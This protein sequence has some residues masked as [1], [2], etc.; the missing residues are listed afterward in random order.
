MNRNLAR[1]RVEPGVLRQVG[2]AFPTV[3]TNNDAHLV[4]RLRR[5]MVVEQWR[6]NFGL[7]LLGRLIEQRDRHRIREVI[8]DVA[9][10]G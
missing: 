1:C 10:Q 2:N 9:V 5:L 4:A 7:L 3:G 6:K 8:F